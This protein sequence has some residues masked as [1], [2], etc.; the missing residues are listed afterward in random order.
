M[1]EVVRETLRAQLQRDEQERERKRLE[2][3]KALDK[4]GSLSEEF[5]ALQGRIDDLRQ[6][7]GLG[8]EERV[9]VIPPELEAVA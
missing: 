9:A 7:L 1:S 8:L 3:Q 4:Y 5:V 6:E 2:L